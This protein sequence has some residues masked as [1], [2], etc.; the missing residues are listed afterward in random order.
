MFKFSDAHVH[1]L[2]SVQKLA[3]SDASHDYNGD[4][5]DIF[6]PD[7]AFCASAE[8]RSVFEE[9]ERLCKAHAKEHAKDF[10]LS[11]G[12][13]PWNPEQEKLSYLEKLIEKNR[14]KAIGECGFDL[15]N[16]ELRAMESEQKKIWRMQA[17]LAIEH[18]LPMVIHCRKALHLLFNETELLKKMPS[19]IFH[20]WAGSIVE[21]NSFLGRGVNAYFCI[22]KGLLRSQKAQVESAK[23]MEIS[24]LLCETDAPY[25]SLKNQAF[26]LPVDIKMISSSLAESRGIAENEKEEFYSQIYT[27]FKQAYFL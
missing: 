25:M 22:G 12:I 11:F 17:E 4:Y 23:K 10:V 3:G 7:V 1:I 8:T 14:I 5:S 24:R 21:S 27:N 19:V 9:Q 2:D 20:G 18:S 15:F 6:M 16:A 13:H 26:A